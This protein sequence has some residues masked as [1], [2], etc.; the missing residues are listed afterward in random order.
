MRTLTI[1]RNKS[2]VGGLM[3]DRVYIQDEQAAEIIIEGVPCRKLGDLK[4]GEQKTFQIDD[5]QQQ[6]FLIVDKVS[7][8]YCNASVTIP[9]GQE[10]VSLSGKHHFVLGS[11]P[12]Q[13][14]GVELS[15]KQ[16]KNNR[17]GM[18]IFIGAAIVGAAIGLFLPGGF[19]GSDTPEPKTFSKEDFSITLTDD[20]AQT[21]QE[22]FFAFYESK[23]AAVFALREDAE[24][25]GNI[26]LDEY[27]DL[28]LKANN[29]AD[30]KMNKGD[31]FLW[32]EY[33][34]TADGQ[35][36]YYM[37]VCCQSENAFWVVN[38]ATPASNREKYATIFMQWAESINTDN[39]V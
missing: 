6:L 17:K 33:T 31:G 12:F 14:D 8:D 7:K 37:A 39:T 27:G 9:E 16:R 11:N 29:R 24:I 18:A 38:F 15:A 35:E 20:F 36:Y 22:G 5:R 32:F 3:K 28:V 23:S 25:F 34:A 30:A 19:L 21:Q 2:F 26:T 4:N 1:T 10:D 13:F